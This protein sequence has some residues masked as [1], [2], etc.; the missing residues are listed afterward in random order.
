MSTNWKDTYSIIS[1]E[2][3]GLL[4][5]DVINAPSSSTQIAK[6]G[7]SSFTGVVK[8]TQFHLVRDRVAL[9]PTKIHAAS[10]AHQLAIATR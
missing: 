5:L 8:I 4:L 10:R 1:V 6:A 9:V 3:A 7:H 2:S